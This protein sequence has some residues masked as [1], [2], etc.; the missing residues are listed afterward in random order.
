M[1]TFTNFKFD[2][3]KKNSPIDFSLRVDTEENCFGPK[4]QVVISMFNGA[5][6]KK[7]MTAFE[8]TDFV[9]RN[10]TLGVSIR[11]AH[12]EYMGSFDEWGQSF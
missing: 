10:P 11:S 12:I 3:H 5:I 7:W 9:L 8:A 4:V 2:V 1:K 6:I